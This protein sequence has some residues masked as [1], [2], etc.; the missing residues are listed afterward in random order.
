MNSYSKTNRNYRR[1]YI[2]KKPF[3]FE[4]RYPNNINI[5]DFWMFL[6]HPTFCYECDYP[7]SKNGPRWGYVLSKFTQMMVAIVASY[8]VYKNNLEPIFEAM[9]EGDRVQ[10]FTAL[11]TPAL[12][13][14]FLGFYAIFEASTNMY[15]ELSG[16]EDRQ[17]Y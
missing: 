1:E 2:G 17:F 6:A 9:R 12:T 5:G 16:F 13:V 8:I 7:L 4:K 11:Y 10:L 14:Y 3:P 15:A